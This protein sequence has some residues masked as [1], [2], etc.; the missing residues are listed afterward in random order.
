MHGD[1]NDEMGAPVASRAALLLGD[2]S[3][4]ANGKGGSMRSS[5]HGAEE[6]K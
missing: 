3:G 4:P 6:P 2:S 1:S 5:I